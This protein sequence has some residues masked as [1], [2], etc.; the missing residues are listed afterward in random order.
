MRRFEA[1]LVAVITYIV[2]KNN[3][4]EHEIRPRELEV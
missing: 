2:K 1:A 3:T 4:K